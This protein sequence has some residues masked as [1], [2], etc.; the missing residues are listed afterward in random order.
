MAEKNNVVVDWLENNRNK[1]IDILK[2]Y[3]QIGH[4]LMTFTVAMQYPSELLT[5]LP[6]IGTYIE[7]RKKRFLLGVSRRQLIIV[8]LKRVRIEEINVELVAME[9][10]GEIGFKRYPFH[11]TLTIPVE[12]I[13]RV[14]KEVPHESAEDFKD[15][16]DELQSRK[17]IF[18]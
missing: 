13:N 17:S 11:A 8:Q 5:W 14:F 12:G 16:V 7:L 10:V 9:K 6:V 2:P 3:L 15:Q 1:A 18:S 4:E